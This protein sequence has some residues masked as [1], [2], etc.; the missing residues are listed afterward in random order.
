MGP[1][2]IASTRYL[3]FYCH[4]TPIVM[5]DGVPIDLGHTSRAVSMKQRLG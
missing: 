2:S 4:L 5:D 1:L 3:A